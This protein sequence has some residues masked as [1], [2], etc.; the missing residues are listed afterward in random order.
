[1]TE[2]RVLVLNDPMRGV[3]PGA[4]RDL[5]NVLHQVADKGVAIILYSTELEELLTLCPEVA[6]VRDHSVTD[7]LSGERLTMDALI[8]GMFGQTDRMDGER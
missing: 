2:P 1:L 8:A 5:L 7:V 6:I 3:D 4:R